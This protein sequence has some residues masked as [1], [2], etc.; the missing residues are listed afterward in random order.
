MNV[1]IIGLGSIAKKHIDALHKISNDFNIY[2][3]RSKPDAQTYLDIK[4][5]YSLEQAQN[6]DFA[7]ISSPT[8]KHLENI[9]SLIKLNIPLFIEKPLYHT[10]EIQTVL[11][12][13]KNKGIK[14]YVAC[15]LRF[16][17]SLN[18]VKREFLDNKELSVNE[19][20]AYCGSYLPDWR[21]QSDYK[22]GYSANKQLGGGV[23]LDLIHELD[24]LYW[25]FG[26]PRKTTKLLKSNSTLNIGS[27]DYANYNLEY[28]NF[29]A[30]V[31]LNYY[32][33]EPLRYLEIV[34]NQFTIKVN[35]IENIVY[36]NG[37]L[38]FKSEQKLLDTYKD[39]LE[40]FINNISGESFNDIN[41]AYEVLK[42][43]L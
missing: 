20:N 32:R 10:L 37:E 36:K 2:V 19:V 33:R 43:C 22:K 4:N 25:M 31:V 34:F 9:Q 12:E 41:E 23:H 42:I 17:E 26:A 35:I 11:S 38:V 13:I 7:I 6:I 3:L 30:S 18:Y 29:V 8:S 14:T 15:N 21:P 27:I 24:Y 28:H 39:Q 5:I 1:L 40:Y 16:L